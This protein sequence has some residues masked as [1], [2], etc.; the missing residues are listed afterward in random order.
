MNM[1]IILEGED[2]TSHG[3]KEAD[4]QLLRYMPAFCLKFTLSSQLSVFGL[5]TMAKK[6]KKK[7]QGIFCDQVSESLLTVLDHRRKQRNEIKSK[8]ETKDANQR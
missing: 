4:G 2:W 1:N 5:R 7:M 8:Y 3:G 6:K